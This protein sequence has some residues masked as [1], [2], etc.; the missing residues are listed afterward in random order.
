[1]SVEGCVQRQQQLL[2]RQESAKAAT[3][4]RQGAGRAASHSVHLRAALPLCSPPPHPPRSQAALPPPWGNSGNGEGAGGSP[5]RGL[6]SARAS[7][8]P[9]PGMLKGRRPRPAASLQY[10]QRRRRTGLGRVQSVE[11][12]VSPFAG[13]VSPS[14]AGAEDAGGCDWD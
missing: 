12:G 11:G 2:Q 9:R 3:P 13:T 10:P 4:L 1:M 7:A 8:A 6:P 14:C 5:A